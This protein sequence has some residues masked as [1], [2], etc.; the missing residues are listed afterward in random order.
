MLRVRTREQLL[1]E[2][3]ENGVTIPKNKNEINEITYES[4][5]KAD[6]TYETAGICNGKVLH[7]RFDLKGIWGSC[8][9]RYPVGRVKFEHMNHIAQTAAIAQAARDAEIKISMCLQHNAEMSIKSESQIRNSK[10][11][12]Y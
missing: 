3:K 7:G 4:A 12:H 9:E 2:L 1:H 8:T 6:L 5:P 11:H 10:R